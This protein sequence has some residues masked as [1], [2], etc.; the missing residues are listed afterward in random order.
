MKPNE[1]FLLVSLRLMTDQL[2]HFCS[3][4]RHQLRVLLIFTFIRL[5]KW[6]FS[7]K[8]KKIIN[9]HNERLLKVLKHLPP[10]FFKPT[11]I[12][13]Q[14]FCHIFLTFVVK[15][16]MNSPNGTFNTFALKLNLFNS[17]C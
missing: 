2:I 7:D 1:V 17:Q 11:V 13:Y 16:G 6:H 3:K 9:L 8:P 15:F 5:Q 12:F 14:K 4:V 10:I